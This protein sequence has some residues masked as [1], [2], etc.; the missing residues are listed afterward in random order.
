[1][2]LDVSDI[3]SSGSGSKSSGSFLLASSSCSGWVS[4]AND[5]VVVGDGDLRRGDDGASDGVDACFARAAFLLA[6]ISLSLCCFR[7]CLLEI[8]D[9]SSPTAGAT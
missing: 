6:T 9:L 8:P 1:M 2:W 7:D 4:C 5:I 3:G